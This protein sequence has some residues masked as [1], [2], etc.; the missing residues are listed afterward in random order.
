MTA[1]S[2]S[3]TSGGRDSIPSSVA[4]PFTARLAR[5]QDAAEL[6]RLR[7][8]MFTSM[9]IDVDKTDW[10]PRCRTHLERCLRAGTLIGAVI[11]QPAGTGLA[12]SALAELSTRIP[13][14][15]RPTGAS[16]YLSSV[17]TDPQ[18]RGRGM[19][20]AVLALLLEELT[21]LGA[22]RVDLHATETGESLYHSLG[23]RPRAGGKEM[24]LV[25]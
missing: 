6:V 21:Q 3:S 23:F 7:A 18:W 12:A 4:V 19:A 20:R 10:Q 13:A 11:D 24:R 17:S 2:R 8:V 9:G 1:S 22:R 25:I 14:P 16:A 5:D 15:S